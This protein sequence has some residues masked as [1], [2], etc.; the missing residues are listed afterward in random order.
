MACIALAVG[1]CVKTRLRARLLHLHERTK[2]KTMSL[3][4]V[5]QVISQ[6]TSISH[7]TGDGRTYAEPAATFA[8]ALSLFNFDLLSFLPPACS[9][10]SSAF[11]PTF[12]TT[13]VRFPRLSTNLHNI[14]FEA[15]LLRAGAEDHG[16]VSRPSCAAVDLRSLRETQRASQG[17]IYCREAI[18]ALG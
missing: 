10:P 14:Y 2:M 4:H 17:S 13:L 9:L 15:L 18:S 7:E 6:F 12:Y 3:I 1:V 11:P 5:C 8:R 16:P